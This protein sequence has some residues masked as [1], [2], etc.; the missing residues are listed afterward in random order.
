MFDLLLA[1]FERFFRFGTTPADRDEKDQ[2]TEE[3]SHPADNQ[4][5]THIVHIKKFRKIEL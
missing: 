1:V 4:R 2:T 5:H 3:K